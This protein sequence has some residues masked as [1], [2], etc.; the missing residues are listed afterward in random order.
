M[1]TFK[2]EERLNSKKLIE[3]L[4]DE[5]KSFKAYPLRVVWLEFD[6]KTTVPAS[7]LISIPAK[8]FRSAS[9]RNLL[10]RRI[11]EAYRKNKEAFYMFLQN[12]HRKCVFAVLYISDEM[13]T[14]NELE[15][16]IIYIFKRL[17]EEYE[18]SD[19]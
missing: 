16:K 1:Q 9:E 13:A 4:F 2:K 18:N 15:Q 19:R 6:N 12:E 17:Q 10:K 7:I 3:K 14:Y 5:G 8:K 11:R